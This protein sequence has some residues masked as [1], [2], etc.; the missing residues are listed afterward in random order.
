[1]FLFYLPRLSRRGVTTLVVARASILKAIEHELF[2]PV[3]VAALVNECGI[4]V[5]T[6]RLS[7]P[8]VG[9]WLA[10]RVWSAFRRICLS[11]DRP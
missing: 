1:M 6:D 2:S 9:P 10:S 4:Y 3:A 5:M 7:Y 8:W 11:L